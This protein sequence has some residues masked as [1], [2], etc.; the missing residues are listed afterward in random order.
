MANCQYVVTG[1]NRDTIIVKII[2]GDKSEFVHLM[3]TGVSPIDEFLH[4]HVNQIAHRMAQTRP[5]V[6][7]ASAVGRTGNF[8]ITEPTVSPPPPPPPPNKQPPM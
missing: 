6:D 8:E 7:L 5:H 4:F 3:W 2:V 1:F